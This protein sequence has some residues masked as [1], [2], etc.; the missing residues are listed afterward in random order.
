[1]SRWESSGQ[2][3][4]WHTPKYIFDA[5]GCWFDLDPANAALMGAN[6]PCSKRY[7][8]N[9]LE[10]EWS[11]YVWLNPP[12]G[13]RNGLTPWIEKFIKHGNGIILVPDRTSAPWF[14]LLAVHT[15]MVLFV[16]RKIKFER[17]DGSFGASPSTGTALFAIGQTGQKA[18]MRAEKA[19]LGI[20][21]RKPYLAGSTP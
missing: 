3:D 12:S 21:F 1:M 2:S 4:E 11:G 9:G 13:K 14:R 15:D 10:T 18:L 19:N 8:Q 20:I 5:L 7:S 17:P 16:S 6:V